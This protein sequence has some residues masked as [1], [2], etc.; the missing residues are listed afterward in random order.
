MD[1]SLSLPVLLFEFQLDI[2]K[3]NLQHQE[4]IESGYASILIIKK[5][6]QAKKA[7]DYVLHSKV[8]LSKRFQI[9]HLVRRDRSSGMKFVSI[10]SL[11]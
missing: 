10:E 9:Q 1:L 5:P 8:I 11:P 7:F 4:V 6:W 3:D 2:P